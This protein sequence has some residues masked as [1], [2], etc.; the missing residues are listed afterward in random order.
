MASYK[1]LQWDLMPSSGVQAHMQ[2]EHLYTKINK[3]KKKKTNKP[4]FE[5]TFKRIKEKQ[6]RK[7]V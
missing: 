1:H 2:A 4:R 3:F 6:S 5:D 7:R